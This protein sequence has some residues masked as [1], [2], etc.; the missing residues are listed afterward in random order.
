[1]KFIYSHS[2]VEPRPWPRHSSQG[3]CWP[4]PHSP[5][6]A[7]LCPGTQV[8]SSRP[9]CSHPGGSSLLLSPHPLSPQGALGIDVTLAVVGRRW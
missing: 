6:R 9:L 8:A 7:Q 3:V 1:M 2:G 5:L 4:G